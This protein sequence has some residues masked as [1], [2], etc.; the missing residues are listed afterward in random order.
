MGVFSRLFR[1]SEKRSTDISDPRFW[2]NDKYAAS[3]S[4]ALVSADSAMKTSTVFACVRIL[5][6]TISSLPVSVYKTRSKSG[7]EDEAKDFY[8]QPIIHDAPNDEQTSFEFREMGQ[9]YLALRGN[10]YFYKVVDEAGHVAKLL[11]LSP[12]RMEPKR[13]FK[14]GKLWYTYTKSTAHDFPEVPNKQTFE[15]NEIWHIKGLSTDGLVGLSPLTCARESIGMAL[16]GEEYGAQ[17]FANAAVTSGVLKHPGSLKETAYERLKN[18]IKEFAASK[19]HAAMILEEGMEWQ[20]IGL[21]N[22]DSQFLES[23]AFQ[24]EDIARFFNVPLILLQHSDKASTYA[25]VEQLGLNFV[26]YTILP[27]VKRWEQSANFSLLTEWERKKGYHISFNLEGLLRGDTAARYDAYA[28]GR[29]WGWLSANDIRRLEN[30]NPIEN[31]DQ[32]IVMPQNIAGKQNPEGEPVPQPKPDEQEEG[33]ND[34]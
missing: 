7:T 19:K 30:M 2:M 1:L 23:R 9:G 32:Y 20:S 13:D 8:L 24:V 4:G 6:E 3:V 10:T 5:S 16:K 25:S 34:E 33:D 26:K 12:A 28:V 11:P 22:R 15:S 18:S 31:G 21:S 17:Y 29:Q 14:T 27:W